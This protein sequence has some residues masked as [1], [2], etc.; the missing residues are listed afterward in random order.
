VTDGAT[1]ASR[2]LALLLLLTAAAGAGACNG[3]SVRV[4]PRPSAT[5]AQRSW[6]TALAT[7]Q[8]AADE[9]RYADVERELGAFGRQHTGT[10]EAQESIFWRMLYRLDPRNPSSAPRDAVRLSDS[11]L[12]A[13]GDPPRRTET[14]V[15]RR[16][17]L[18]LDS[19]RQA[20]PPRDTVIV[21]DTTRNVAHER[22]LEA[23]VKTLQDS[24]TATLAELERIRKRLAQPRP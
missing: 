8:R 15:L 11:L 23:Q 18:F 22:E 24:L 12:L 14:L 19:L 9:G 16:T 7:A 17:A 6:P 10:P 20:P 13:S 21:R 1:G 4:R 3:H 2:T 5:P